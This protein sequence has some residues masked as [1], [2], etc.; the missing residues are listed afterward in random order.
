MS[1][2]SDGARAPP[3]M[4]RVASQEKTYGLIMKCA[5]LAV[6]LG[7]VMMVANPYSNL[8]EVSTGHVE[9]FGMHD[10]G[11]GGSVASG[12]VASSTTNIAG[13]PLFA[14]TMVGR[15]DGAMGRERH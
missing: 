14:D 11:S 15:Y 1:G 2:A 9:S 3:D 5:V 4:Q 6:I 13:C 10:S 8:G 7:I 12:A